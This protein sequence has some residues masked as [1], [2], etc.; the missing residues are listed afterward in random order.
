MSFWN[1]LT[2]RVGHEAPP[3][4]DWHEDYLH[5]LRHAVVNEAHRNIAAAT[6]VTRIA[7]ATVRT[8][9][10]AGLAAH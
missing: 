1:A 6:R 3:P 9:R 7:L 8:L 2:G 5:D 4:P 10:D